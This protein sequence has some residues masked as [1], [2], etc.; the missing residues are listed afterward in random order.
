MVLVSH[1]R[2][3][4]RTTVDELWLVADGRVQ[5]FDGDL[6]DYAGWLAA[7]RA[8]AKT[9]PAAAEK[10][11]RREAA[12]GQANDRAAKKSALAERRKL[13]REVEKLDAQLAGWHRDK[14]DVDS[15]LADP[16]LYA[17]PDRA[18]IDDLN[19]RQGELAAAIEAAETRWLE[20]HEALE[21]VGD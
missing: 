8:Q 5:P 4:L 15:R 20:V 13:E 14:A 12:V 21:A 2:H 3:L 6:E 19:R 1:D 7:R 17:A 11:A 18:R 9:E 16:A 10:A